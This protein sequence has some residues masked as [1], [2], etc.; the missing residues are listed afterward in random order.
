MR[1]ALAM[2]LEHDKPSAALR[3]Y[4][5][6]ADL[7]QNADRYAEARQF[8]EDGL[9]LARRVGNRYWETIFLG[10]VYPNFALGRW[11]ETVR[12]MSELQPEWF[13]HTRAAFNQ[14]FVAFGV[15]AHVHRGDLDAAAMHL[16]RFAELESSA[17]VQ[18]LTEFAC[19]KACLLLAEGDAEGALRSAEE[20]ISGQRSLSTID[21]RVKESFVTAVEAA[22]AMGDLAKV[23]ELLDT[24]RSLPPGRR[25]P[26]L[27]AH[28]S[29][30]GAR[31]SADRGSGGDVASAFKGAVGLFR[32]MGIPF[33]MAVTMLEYAEWLA[34]Q[35]RRG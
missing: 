2:A 33:W 27:A 24:V 28:S 10:F 21:H 18:D 1:T 4:N 9:A 22:F 19:G 17:D 12:M 7:T 29:R 11:D 25:T 13:S 15:A 3:A 20:A 34:G 32:E 14:G 8:L 35:G 6:L 30:L 23:E 5:N 31:L 16:K 26:F